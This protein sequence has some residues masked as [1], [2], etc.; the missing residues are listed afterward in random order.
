MHEGDTGMSIVPGVKLVQLCS[1]TYLCANNNN[2]TPC[3]SFVGPPAV[4]PPAGAAFGHAHFAA[5]L[6]IERWRKRPD[7]K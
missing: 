1:M 6:P 3:P 5:N 4:M 2:S 7:A